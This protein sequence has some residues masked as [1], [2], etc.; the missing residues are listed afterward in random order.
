MTLW[1]MFQKCKCFPKQLTVAVPAPFKGSHAQAGWFQGSGVPGST[2]FTCLLSFVWAGWILLGVSCGL[3]SFSSSLFPTRKNRAG[4]DSL[5]RQ[6]W[7]PRTTQHQRNWP[8][9]ERTRRPAEKTRNKIPAILKLLVLVA[10]AKE[11]LFSKSSFNALSTSKDSA[12]FPQ[13]L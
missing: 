11:E 3:H 8:W 7:G 6:L 9:D 13:L 10:V 2:L 1:E 12:Y 5:G 4:W